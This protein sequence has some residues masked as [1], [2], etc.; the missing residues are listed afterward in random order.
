M[1]QLSKKIILAIKQEANPQKAK[2]LQRF[3]KTGRGEYAEGDL[4]LGLTV[5]QQRSIVKE[6][7]NL[8]DLDDLSILI[9]NAYHEVRLVALLLLVELFHKVKTQEEK[10][11]LINFYLSHTS[12]INNWDLVD[13]S[14][15]KIVGQYLL[16]THQNNN[17]QQVPRLLF[18]LANSELLWERRIAVI[19]T[20]PFVRNGQFVPTFELAKLLL[21]DQADL[22]HKAVGWLLREVGK[23][24]ETVLCCFLDQYTLVMPRTMLRYA[25]ER[26]SEKKRLYY[27]KKIN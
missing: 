18:K 5:P 12:Y 7:K 4:F 1:S 26:F 15:D 3:F 25:I 17:S 13:L 20:F 24:D 22:I 2:I 14:A 8:V 23:R 21:N 10:K 16:S 9:I 11:Q 19:A 27:L 6:F